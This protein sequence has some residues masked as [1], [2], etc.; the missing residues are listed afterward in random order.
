MAEEV[1]LNLAIE[2]IFRVL[3]TALISW[4]ILCTES[5]FDELYCV[6]DFAAQQLASF[7]HSQHK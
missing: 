6:V 4:S 5:E 7:D 2:P 1:P 3:F